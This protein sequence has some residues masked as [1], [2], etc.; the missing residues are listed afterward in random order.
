MS[1]AKQDANP[2]LRILTKVNPFE[3]RFNKIVEIRITSS[4][5]RMTSSGDKSYLYNCFK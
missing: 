1:Q 2:P 4:F 5:A 3:I